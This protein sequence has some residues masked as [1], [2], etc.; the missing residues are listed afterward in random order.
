MIDQPFFEFRSFDEEIQRK[1][2]AVGQ[3]VHPLAAALLDRAASRCRPALG[4]LL[5][6]LE[7]LPFDRVYPNY[8]NHPVRV[9][10]SYVTLRP[11]AS[12]DELALALCHNCVEAGLAD[13]IALP[14]D[15]RRAVDVLTIDREREHDPVYLSAF[16][17]R[18]ED[19][20][21]LLLKTLDKLDNVL[22]W[23]RF[24]VTEHDVR[25]VLDQ[26]CPRAEREHPQLA[27]YF[28]ELV[29]YVT[30][31]AVVGRYVSV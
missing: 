26:V 31:P 20:A 27:A 12:F 23:V 4:R 18:I 14:P 22:E 9:A 1:L 29:A 11:H 19:A 15:V 3:D 7:Q 17:D 21:L 2:A 5:A 16:Y 8:L 25:V 10:G 13:S 6:T 24:D 28:R 30:S